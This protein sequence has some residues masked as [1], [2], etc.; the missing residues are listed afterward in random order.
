MDATDHQKAAEPRDLIPVP[1][2]DPAPKLKPGSG[3]GVHS[4]EYCLYCYSPMVST[5]GASQRCAHCGR[6]HLRVDHGSYWTREPKLVRLEWFIKLSIAATV[7][8]AWLFISK[9]YDLGRVSSFLVGPMLM[10][11]GVMWWTAGLITRK[12]RY[13]SG[14]VLWGASIGLLV[15]GIPILLFIL[16]VIARRDSFGSEYWR[17]YLILASPAMP[18]SLLGVLLHAFAAQFEEFKEQRLARTRA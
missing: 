5:T 14:R 9:T 13:F 3:R 6:V 10:L 4:L 12:S 16:D 8:G 2:L 7:I 18:M 1:A 17:S 15:L 11:G